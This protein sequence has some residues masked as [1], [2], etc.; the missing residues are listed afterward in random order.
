MIKRTLHFGNPAYLSLS[1][2]QML[3]KLPEVETNKELHENFKKESVLSIPIED[4]GIVILDHSRITITQALIGKLLNNN[5]A[6]ISCN[7]HHLPT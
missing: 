3:I 7:A 4:I 6:L 1:N 2:E 5:A